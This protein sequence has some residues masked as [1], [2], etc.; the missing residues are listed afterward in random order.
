MP[1]VS[2]RRKDASKLVLV[3]S[4][5]NDASLV[6]VGETVPCVNERNHTSYQ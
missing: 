3:V 4:G 5:R 1:A 2:K 6:S